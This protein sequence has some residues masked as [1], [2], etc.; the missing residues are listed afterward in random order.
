MDENVSFEKGKLVWPVDRKDS[1]KYKCKIVQVMD[2]LFKIHYHGWKSLSGC[3]GSQ[4]AWMTVQ[5]AEKTDWFAI[6][7]SLQ[8]NWPMVMQSP[9]LELLMLTPLGSCRGI[10][11]VVLPTKELKD[12]CCVGMIIRF[13]MN[14]LRKA[15]IRCFP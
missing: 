11:L 4:T 6:G 14:T 10:L 13:F 3:Q 1:Q 5:S 9:M 8:E 15:W 2:E 7:D 12:L